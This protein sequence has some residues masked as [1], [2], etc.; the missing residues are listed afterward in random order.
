MRAHCL[1]K[2][3]WIIMDIGY[4]LKYVHAFATGQSRM[5]ISLPRRPSVARPSHAEQTAG[6]PAISAPMPDEVVANTHNSMLEI[7]SVT[8]R[9]QGPA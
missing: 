8:A 1:V 2:A 4:I 9:V 7:K 6:Q 5:L 3:A